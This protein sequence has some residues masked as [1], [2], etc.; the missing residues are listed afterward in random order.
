MPRRCR[1]DAHF[2]MSIICN[3]FNNVFGFLSEDFSI[4]LRRNIMKSIWIWSTFECQGLRNQRGH[5]SMALPDIRF[6]LSSN[7][8]VCGFD[9]D[10]FLF[11]NMR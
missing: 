2:S 6:G 3:S 1:R 7:S 9:G 5:D 8:V 11:R 4:F 10:Y